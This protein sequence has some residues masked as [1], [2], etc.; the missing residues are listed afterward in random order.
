MAN[1]E[2]GTKRD[3]PNCGAR[4]YDLKKDP[5]HCP[6]CDHEFTPDVLLKSRK[7]LREEEEA[8]HKAAKPSKEVDDDGEELDDEVQEIDAEAENTTSLDDAEDEV[9]PAKSKRAKSL[10]E[11]D[12]DDDEDEDDELADLD[13]PDDD[14]DTLLDDDD[15]DED[16]VAGIAIGGDDDDDR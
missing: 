8:A 9:A 14:D 2:L 10:D 3:C 12:D 16:D 7:R 13:L 1:E 5:A 6:K 15:D 4:F 11:D